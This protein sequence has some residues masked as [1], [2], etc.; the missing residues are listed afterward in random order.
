MHSMLTCNIDQA[1]EL[2]ALSLIM[3]KQITEFKE[4][5]LPISKLKLKKHKEL[6]YHTPKK[7]RAKLGAYQEIVDCLIE[8]SSESENEKD[9]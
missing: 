1:Q 4:T 7:K 3:T 5:L 8:P 9:R 6:D 2:S